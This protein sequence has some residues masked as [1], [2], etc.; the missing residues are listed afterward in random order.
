MDRSW[1]WLRIVVLCVTVGAALPLLPLPN[2]GGAVPAAAQS[3]EQGELR[4]FV[5]C[6]G[7]EADLEVRDRINK[8]FEAAHPGVTIKQETLPAGTNYFEKLQTLIA[9]GTPPDV[10][11]MWEGYV[12][13][14]AAA[15]HL[16]DLEPFFAADPDIKKDDFDPRMLEV[17][18]WNG[19]V[20]SLPIEFVPYPAA[21]FYNVDLFDQAGLAYPDDT[22]TWKELREA[23]LKLTRTEGDRVTQWG[24]LFDYTFYPTWLSIL[25]ANGADFF[26]AD[27]SKCAVT[28]PAAVEA[29]QWWADLVTKDKVAPGPGVLQ[30][31]QGAANGFK[32]GTVAMYLGAGWEP[33]DFDK[34]A[35]LRYAMAPLPRSL[36]G[37]RGTYL[38]LLTWAISPQTK[39]KQTAWEYVKYFATEGEKERLATISSIP[40]Y[41][42]LYSLWLTPEREQKGYELYI[43]G[44]QY[45][46]V[47]GAGAKWEKISTLAQ[48]ELDLLFAGQTTAAEAA[49]KIC[50]QTDEELA[51]P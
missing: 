2:G 50:Q 26:T 30:G 38:M 33:P 43:D 13:P 25:W 1:I 3:Y 51:R 6:A 19:R 49:A 27:Q 15:G 5:C 12:Q 20:Y 24:L 16:L 10:F 35:N 39:M 14:Y 47:P 23:A 40:A 44:L 29:L 21:L 34:T 37:Q 46:R 7:G 18:S 28:E 42:P 11:D 41:K 17:D 8:A 32:T 9:S 36:K 22:W 31:F 4:V 48:A 45:A